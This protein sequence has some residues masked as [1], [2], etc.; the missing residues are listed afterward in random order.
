MQPATPLFT[1]RPLLSTATVA[2]LAVACAA[3][4]VGCTGLPGADIIEP[5]LAPATFTDLPIFST[6]TPEQEP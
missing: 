4:L 2:A 6:P 5:A 1:A 3:L